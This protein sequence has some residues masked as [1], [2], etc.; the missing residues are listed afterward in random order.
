MKRVRW[1][2][3]VMVA[4]ALVAAACSSD[5]ADDTTT[6]AGGDAATTTAAGDDMVDMSGADFNL[7]GAP[8]AGEGDATNGFINLYNEQKGSNITLTGSDSYETQ[9]RVR[10]EGGDPPDVSFT[11]Q[12]AM[13]CEFAEA[14]AL[15]ALEDLGFDI[16]DLNATRGQFLMDIGVCADGKH[17][18]IPWYPN[19]KSIVFYPKAVFDAQGYEVPA[20]WKEMVTLSEQMVADGFAPWCFGYESD[21]A[22]GWPGTDWIEDIMVRMHGVE[23]YKAWTLGELRFNTPEVKAAFEKFE[24]ILFGEGFVLGGAENVAATNFRDSPLP[25]FNDPPSCLMLKQGSFIASYFPTEGVIT[26]FAF[27]TIDGGSGALGGGDYLM[28]F[29]DDP[30]VVQFVKDVI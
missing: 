28:I 30:Q 25:M 3:I 18:G 23:K 2:V 22:T 17:Y 26:T 4:F 10:V 19:S 15:V 5:D 9:I 12:P 29:K 1:L 16:A 13:V 11:P 8:V 7:F 24:E 27:P 21:A 14:G 6:T 20:T